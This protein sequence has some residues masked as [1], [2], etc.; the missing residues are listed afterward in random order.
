[1]FSYTDLFFFLGILIVM[2]GAL[3]F[4]ALF[5]YH[6]LEDNPFDRNARIMFPICLLLLCAGGFFLYLSQNESWLR[7]DLSNHNNRILKLEHKKEIT[8]QKINEFESRSISSEEWY[9]YKAY[10]KLYEEFSEKAH[11]LSEEAGELENAIAK[12]KLKEIK[13]K[14]EEA[15]IK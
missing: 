7:E 4:F 11:E 15:D 8:E 12:K 3:L 10:R 1:M 13:K 6:C 5:S 9:E 2:L 14:L